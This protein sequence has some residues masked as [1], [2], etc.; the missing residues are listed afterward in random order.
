M[1]FSQI[2]RS[3][4]DPL[5][6]IHDPNS[7]QCSSTTSIIKQCSSC[8]FNIDDFLHLVVQPSGKK[9]HSLAFAL[10]V[11]NQGNDKPVLV[12]M[13]TVCVGLN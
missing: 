5:S 4:M 12:S 10:G 3:E 9:W 7:R 11:E 2:V 6:F 1:S 13:T 8:E